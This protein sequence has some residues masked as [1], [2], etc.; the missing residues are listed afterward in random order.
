MFE[1][2]HK[3]Q[4]EE[5]KTT[6]GSVRI[7][8]IVFSPEEIENILPDV[9]FKDENLQFM[10]AEKDFNNKKKFNIYKRFIPKLADI[11]CL[12]RFIEDECKRSKS[13]FSFLAEGILGL[14]FRD[15]Y[16][17]SLARC[18]IDVG[19]T[20]NDSHTGADAC[21]YDDKKQ[22]IV[23][24]EAKFYSKFSDGITKII[25]D[26]CKND[27]RN[28]LESLQTNIENCDES[29]YIVLKNLDVEKFAILSL[30]QF[31]N[32]KMIFAGFVLHAEKSDVT[33]YSVGNFYGRY[34]VSV[35]NLCGNISDSLNMD[36]IEGKYE[37]VL[38]HLPICD[39]KSLIKRIID[40]ARHK[41]NE[42]Q[43]RPQS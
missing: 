6:Y 20:A 9:V 26:F 10:F 34:Q 3:V 14:V 15:L 18:L 22:L 16:G 24:G 36:K 30:G 8:N 19:D 11:S 1:Y 5:N 12:D 37:I 4:F 39:K 35:N 23:L 33:R 41:L 25:K 7:R 13:F 28:K 29:Y 27:I 31:M 32:Q 38:L 42:L 40:K 21:M 2:E 17:Y 43:E